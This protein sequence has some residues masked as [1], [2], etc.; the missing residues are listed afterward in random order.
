[1]VFVRCNT[2]I[3]TGNLTQNSLKIYNEEN[4][5]LEMN[6]ITSENEQLTIYTSK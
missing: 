6:D 2:P 4:E 1:M 3:L 5:D